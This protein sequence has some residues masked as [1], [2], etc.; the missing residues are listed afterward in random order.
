[1]YAF[2]CPSCREH[3]VIFE[4]QVTAIRNDE[5]GIHVS[6]TCWCGVP[7]EIHTGLHHKVEE[8]AQLVA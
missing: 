4:S 7:G 5:T 3:W 2:H 1:M 8:P 6:I